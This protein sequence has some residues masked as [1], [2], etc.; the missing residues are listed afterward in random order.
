M[1]QVG[2][3]LEWS[4]KMLEFED[5]LGIGDEASKM[6]QEKKS[7]ARILQSLLAAEDAKEDAGDDKA[8]RN[9]RKSYLRDRRCS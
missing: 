2:S 7:K 9:E 8:H 6:I 3:G 1:V 5:F 4:Q